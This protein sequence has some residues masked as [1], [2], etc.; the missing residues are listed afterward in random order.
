MSEGDF[1]QYLAE[2]REKVVN[3]AN[4][5]LKS[6]N[7]KDTKGVTSQLWH[8]IQEYEIYG[9]GLASLP[10]FGKMSIPRHKGTFVKH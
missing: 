9:M 6:K 4:T 5:E 2:L 8:L 3:S 7:L 1:Q 10:A